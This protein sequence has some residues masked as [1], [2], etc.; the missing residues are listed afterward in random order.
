M[1][2]KMSTKKFRVVW[3][4]I[5]AFLLILMTALNVAA[6]V[7]HQSLDTYL[8]RGE[9]IVKDNKALA[10]EISFYDQKFKDTDSETGSVSQGLK[11]AKDITDEGEVLLK[12]KG[13][14]PLAKDSDITVFGYRY[15]SPVYGGTG[16]GNIS[17]DKDWVTTVEAGMNKY[18]SVNKTVTDIM[19]SATPQEITSDSVTDAKA[20]DAE[21]GS[22]GFS[23]AGTSIMEFNPDI[24]AP[25]AD[26]CAETT[27]VVFLGRVGGEGANLQ[28]SEYADGTEHQLQLTAYEKDT[29]KF[30]K[31]HCKQVVAVINSSNVMELGE[32]MSGELEVDAIIWIGG[33]GA[34]GYESLADIMAGEVNPSG[35]TADIWD[36]DLKA[37]PTFANFGED[38]TYT[39]TKDTEVASNYKG[40]YYLEYEEG[41]YYGYRYYETASDLGYLNYEDSVV[42]PFGYGLS[43][44]TFEQSITNVSEEEDEIKITV[45]IRNTGDVDGKEIVQLYYN[46][47]YTDYDKENGIEK[48]T[49]NLA[50]FEKAEVKA[51]ETKEVT[52]TIAKEEMASY[53]DTHDNGD[54]TTGCWML[55]SGDYEL[56]L[57]KD[58]HNEWGSETVNISETIWYMN[59]NPRQTEKTAQSAM[60]DEGNIL[61][62]PEAGADAKYMAATN[63]FEDVTE[64]M[65]EQTVML[66]R[67]DWENTQPTVPEEK[68]LSE[69]RL[70]DAVNFDPVNDPVLGTNKDSEIFTDKLPAA[71]ADN[72]LTL[73]DM[74]GLGYYD[75]NWE[76]LLDQID[77]DSEQL[78]T[79]LYLSAFTT[80]ELT[81]VGKPASVDHDGPQGW[82]MTGAEGGPETCGYCAEVVV[83][84]TWNEELAYA[85]GEAIGQEALTVGYTGWY[86][87][88]IN[89]HRSAFI[90]RN[91]EY[92]SEDP[93]LT[94]KMAAK[95]IS[96][97]ADQGVIS[98][99]KHFGM[100]EYEGPACSMSIWA[101]EQTIREIYLK[102][103]EIPVKEARMTLKYVADE[104]GTTAEK[105]MKGATGIMASAS[106][107]GTKWCAAN[108]PLLTNVV[109]GEWGYQGVISTDMFLQCSENIQTKVF[110][111]GNCLKM[112]YMP[113][114]EKLDTDN[115][116]D[117]L[118]VR[119]AVKGVCYAY[120]NS[121]LMEGMAPGAVFE[122]G[123]SPWKIG[124]YIADA[125]VGIFAIVMIAVMLRRK[126]DKNETE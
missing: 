107:I 125:V 1:K 14:L 31:E 29:V 96:G 71:K 5:L 111:S 105:T 101:S 124:L 97:A 99:M 3:S 59:E 79:L 58:S 24:Y 84:S 116:V 21:S 16:S 13:V 27:G 63:Q 70:A 45:E 49:K 35:K 82:G 81:S 123:I 2:K 103:G 95:C 126:N 68:E 30:A 72:D 17:T 86:G 51:G 89:I 65:K 83:A 77:Y 4:C 94:G 44:T 62:Y 87:P 98:Y 48:A 19:K 113:P 121:N 12:N 53:D 8:G 7:F 54:G 15:M 67:A 69:E 33:P 39:N 102:A 10:E 112:W 90:G 117:R 76:L 52:L 41:I 11:V 34:T 61:N 28:V 110:R 91:F 46:P 40:L 47:P 120:A 119:N 106:M 37:N 74:R 80:G 6:N 85:Y 75:E 88:G 118:A 64:Y 38:R 109:K 55:E 22:K 66:T 122:Y 92:Y 9:R 56:V 20:A 114:A 57:G 42:F 60:D 26:S 23:G 108:Y 32:L 18:F 25:A 115:A 73:S 78:D 43:Y 36:A 50:A 100:N 104:D 93:L